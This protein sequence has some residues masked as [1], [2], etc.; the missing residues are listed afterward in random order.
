MRVIKASKYLW[1]ISN[2]LLMSI[3][4]FCYSYAWNVSF[5]SILSLEILFKGVW[6]S[7]GYCVCLTHIFP[8]RWTFG[9][10]ITG[11]T[12]EFN[13]RS[14]TQRTPL[15]IW[16]P[17][18]G[19]GQFS[20]PFQGGLYTNGT[21]R[22]CFSVCADKLFKVLRMSALVPSATLPPLCPD[23]YSWTALKRQK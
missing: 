3:H 8:N 7:V 23:S 16:T 18:K 13:E 17:I 22:S 4:W 2:S 1:M 5:D 15:A 10:K 11:Q 19:Y 20:K 6:R 14:P 21:E 9:L 12:N